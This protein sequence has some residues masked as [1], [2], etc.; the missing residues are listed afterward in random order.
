MRG[1]RDTRGPARGGVPRAQR[2]DMWRRTTVP[3]APVRSCTRSHSAFASHRP[4]PPIVPSVGRRRPTS[5]SITTP[6]VGDLDDDRASRHPTPSRRLS[7]RRTSRCSSRPHWW[8]ARLVDPPETARTAGPP[9]A[10]SRRTSRTE[11]PSNSRSDMIRRRF[12]QW[13]GEERGA[14]VIVREHPLAFC[15]VVGLAQQR[16]GVT[17]PAAR[18]PR[19]GCWCRTGTAA[20]TRAPR[21]T[22]R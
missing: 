22:R 17:C 16:V 10:T 14:R 6:A 9:P 20:A 11:R 18:S 3:F 1:S 21:G 19:R 12:R 8:R 7:R 2:Q 4:R 13:L 15:R 5:G